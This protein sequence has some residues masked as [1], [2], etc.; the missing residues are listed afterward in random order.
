MVKLAKPRRSRRKEALINSTTT[1]I[2]FNLRERRERRELRVKNMRNF[3]AKTPGRNG[4]KEPGPNSI[5]VKC[6]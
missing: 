5:G 1:E 3:N 2:K 4:A 6:L